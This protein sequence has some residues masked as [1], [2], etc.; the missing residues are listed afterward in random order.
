ML[1]SEPIEYE[2]KAIKRLFP[3][4]V[5]EYWE[6]IDKDEMY[7]PMNPLNPFFE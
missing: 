4:S 2:M 1:N 5:T 3:R 7:I 6:N